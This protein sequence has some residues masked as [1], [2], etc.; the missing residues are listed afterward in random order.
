[1][2]YC[3]VEGIRTYYEA[4][5]EGIP[6]MLIHGAGQDTLSWHDNISYLS[7]RYK[8]FAIDLPGHGKSALIKKRPTKTNKE[9]ADFVWDFIKALKIEQ[10]ILIGHSMGAGIAVWVSIDHP[11]AIK[12]VVAVDGGAAFSGPMGVSYRPGL[13]QAIEVNPTDWGRRWFCPWLDEQLLRKEGKRWLLTQLDALHTHHSV[14]FLHTR[15][16][17]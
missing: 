16:L 3:N 5:G 2:A 11:D 10:S 12:A 9:Y 17:I 1:M 13:L 4:E 6:L 7:K 15:L 8:V 14:I